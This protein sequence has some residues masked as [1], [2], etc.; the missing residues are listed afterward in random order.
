MLLLPGS[1]SLWIYPERIH[2][3]WF[4]APGF[5]LHGAVVGLESLSWIWFCWAGRR[6]RFWV[7]SPCLAYLGQGVEAEGRMEVE[8]AHVEY[9]VKTV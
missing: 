7:C 4:I 3:L 8:R 5:D 2:R 6:A 9:L 1:K